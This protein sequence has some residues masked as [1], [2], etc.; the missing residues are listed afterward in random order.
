MVWYILSTAPIFGIYSNYILRFKLKD[1]SI[2]C[3]I[4][5]KCLRARARAAQQL[6]PTF[7]HSAER[8]H[9]K[10]EQRFYVML[11]CCFSLS[12]T[13]TLMRSDTFGTAIILTYFECVC[14]HINMINFRKLILFLSRSCWWGA[15]Y[16]TCTD[17]AR[18]DFFNGSIKIYSSPPVADCIKVKY[19]RCWCQ[20]LECPISFMIII[21]IPCDLSSASGYYRHSSAPMCFTDRFIYFFL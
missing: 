9:V 18:C 8:A 20:L 4:W 17:D 10:F 7:N 11:R 1:N 2:E 3:N 19:F 12:C 6:E 15:S 16:F 13:I 21:K 5:S 14:I